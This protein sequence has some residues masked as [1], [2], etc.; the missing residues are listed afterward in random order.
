MN[1]SLEYLYQEA[2]KEHYC[3]IKK[4]CTYHLHRNPDMIEDCCQEVFRLY[5]EALLKNQKIVNVGAWLSRVAYTEVLRVEKQAVKNQKLVEFY[6][7]FDLDERLG[8]NY[9]YIEEI[10]KDKFSDD[11][12]IHSLLETLTEEER[13]LLNGCFLNPCPPNELAAQ[14]HI[15]VNYL[16]KKKW[17]LK[18]KL[19][20]NMPYIINK[21]ER[22]ALK[23]PNS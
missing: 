5:Y 9:D 2:W 17:M 7:E 14:L 19:I 23:R 16:Y 13:H 21:I 10:I 15:N 20:D 12:L 11:A 6:D 18:K 1:K 22:E 3:R 8:I 4:F